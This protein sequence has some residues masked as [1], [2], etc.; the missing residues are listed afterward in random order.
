[1]G[2][3]VSRGTVSDARTRY[4]GWLIAR[5]RPRLCSHLDAS[6]EVAGLVALGTNFWVV[7]RLSRQASSVVLR[8]SRFRLDL[9]SGKLA[10]A[11]NW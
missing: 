5:H 1:M 6:L 9:V 3:V 11:D 10:A 8:L 4:H 2:W 7:V